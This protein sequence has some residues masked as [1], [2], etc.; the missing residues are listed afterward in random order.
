MAAP[1]QKAALVALALS[2]AALAGAA[3]DGAR[4]PATGFG[5]LEHAA[6]VEV[7]GAEL[8]CA[9]CH[10]SG[11]R[12]RPGHAACFGACHG[13]PPP[14]GRAGRHAVAELSDER[15]ALCVTCHAPAGLARGAVDYPPYEHDPDFTLV[16]DHAAHAEVPRGCR[17]C[18]GADPERPRRRAADP[19]QR[20]ARCHAGGDPA[21]S[22]AQCEGC[23]EKAISPIRRPVSEPGPLPVADTFSHRRH[24]GRTRGAC[25]PC[26]A[27]AAAATGERVPSPKKDAC[28]TCHDGE[29]AFSM[30]DAQC[31]RC[32]QTP[33]KL[34]PRSRPDLEGAHFS[35]RRHDTGTDESDCKACHALD[36]GGRPRPLTDHR[37]C[38]HAGCHA[39]DFARLGAPL[40][41]ACH[42]GDEPWRRLHVD[43][44]PPPATEFGARFDHA[45]HRADDCRRCHLASTGQRD[46]ELPANHAACSG[47]GC[48]DRGAAP[49][50]DRCTACHR[51]GLVAERERTRRSA[52]W[53]VRARFDHRA[54]ALDPRTGA[55]LACTACHDGAA[56]AS[57]MAAMPT[58]PKKSCAP[59]HDGDIAFKMTGHGCARCH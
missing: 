35:H 48:H 15:R 56:A 32:H 10:P 44:R 5:H 8:G 57:G 16:L 38:G 24:L 45:V 18:H 58:P 47:T 2:I 12:G 6:K 27:E 26:H 54:H 39:D 21:P 1:V 51:P 4:E 53:S 17:D 34:A 30:I 28:R 11:A 9:D 23:H 41:S 42:V 14:K 33:A 20:C 40:C 55:E 29:R 3:P 46:H 7:T 13:D 31:R 52:P 49:A 50:L 37:A 43:R 59:C 19:H 25:L 22:M 36:A